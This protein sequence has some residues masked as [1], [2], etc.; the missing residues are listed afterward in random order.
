ME[1]PLSA[2]TTVMPERAGADEGV[3][4]G[5]GDGQAVPGDGLG[6]PESPR[7][8]DRDLRTRP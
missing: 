7:P 3:G 5:T 1:A 4:S 2:D 6:V 8:S